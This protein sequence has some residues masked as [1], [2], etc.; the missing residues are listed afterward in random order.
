M[1]CPR[2]IPRTTPRARRATVNNKG[3]AM[4]DPQAKALLDRIA[5]AGRPAVHTLSPPEARQTYRDS[6]MPLQPAPPEVTL[7]EDLQA[8]GPHGAIGLR[9]YRPQGSRG[10]ELLPAL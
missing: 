10:D 1:Y 6:R 3:D 7:A 8:P 9:L 2:T 4:L 5:A